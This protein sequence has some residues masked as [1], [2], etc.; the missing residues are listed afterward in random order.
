[1]RVVFVDGFLWEC[2]VTARQTLL[3]KRAARHW[4]EIRLRVPERTPARDGS[5]GEMADDVQG[6]PPDGGF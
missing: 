2:R 6:D 5:H 3:Q 1:M 4:G